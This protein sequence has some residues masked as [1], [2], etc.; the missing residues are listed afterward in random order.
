MCSGFGL[1]QEDTWTDTGMPQLDGTVDVLRHLALVRFEGAAVSVS[2]LVLSE[3]DVDEILGTLSLMYH[4]SVGVASEPGS[5]IVTLQLV[6]GPLWQEGLVKLKLDS[7]FQFE[8]RLSLSHF[9]WKLALGRFLCRWRSWL[10]LFDWCGG[11]GFLGVA[12]FV[13]GCTLALSRG[14]FLVFAATIFR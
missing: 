8:S 7:S 13:A 14:V 12:R 1:Q 4:R 10:R 3:S 5:M 9:L 6:P 2:L 11:C